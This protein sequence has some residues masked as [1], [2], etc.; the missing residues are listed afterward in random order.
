MSQS[1]IKKRGF[2]TKDFG[3]EI[4]RTPRK[5]EDEKV[6]LVSNQ[7]GADFK[8]PIDKIRVRDI[9]SSRI[10][11]NPQGDYCWFVNVFKHIRTPFFCHAFR[12]ESGKRYDA[13][14]DAGIFI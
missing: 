11:L 5:V 7:E 6:I 10:C 13:I 14:N 9:I 12:T 3:V 8:E 4:D 1:K 2:S